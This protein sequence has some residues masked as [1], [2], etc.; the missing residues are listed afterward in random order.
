MKK[1]LSILGITLG[2]KISIIADTSKCQAKENELM[3]YIG[4]V[5]DERFKK[6]PNYC[7]VHS[8]SKSVIEG[9]LYLK[10]NNCHNYS[11]KVF[12]QFKELKKLTK[13]YCEGKT[14]EKPTKN[15]FSKAFFLFVNTK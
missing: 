12:R 2:L 3:I 15:I 6:S 14:E 5:L 9:Q 10:E 4:E 11:K 7:L 8:G 1:L 13:D